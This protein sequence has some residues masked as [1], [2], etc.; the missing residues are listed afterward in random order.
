MCRW[1]ENPESYY[2]ND[3]SIDKA[4]AWYVALREKIR[5]LYN[6]L[7]PIRE[8]EL[9]LRLSDFKSTPKLDEMLRRG[10]DYLSSLGYDIV[11]LIETAML[12]GRELW[13]KKRC[14]YS[15][16]SAEL[17]SIGLKD[18]R[19]WAEVFEVPLSE[20]AG[21]NLDMAVEYTTSKRIDFLREYL[22]AIAEQTL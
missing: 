3:S 18:L 4:I 11:A 8:G 10:R 20:E 21:G 14:H 17:D 1:L 2:P 13:F 22:T 15:D 12:I 9:I 6:E 19:R 16:Y 7:N 5:T